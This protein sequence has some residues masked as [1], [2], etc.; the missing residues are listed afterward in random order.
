MPKQKAVNISF[1]CGKCKIKLA[2]RMLSKLYMHNEN[3]F[4]T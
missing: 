1:K 2:C 3:S 4:K